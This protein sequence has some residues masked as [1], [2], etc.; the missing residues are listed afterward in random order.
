ML[1]AY[2]LP[3]NPRLFY[4]S[5]QELKASVFHFFIIYI[6]LHETQICTLNFL[7][8]T[9][10]LISLF[11]FYIWWGMDFPLA[12]VI[13]NTACKYL[14]KEW[15]NDILCFREISGHSF[16]ESGLLRHFLVYILKMQIYLLL[17]YLDSIRK[18]KT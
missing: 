8:L 15:Y 12:S 14:L 3:W 18:I 9:T 6:S 16:K 2:Y 11:F 13:I 10:L 5:I 7:F 1:I 17:I 4:S